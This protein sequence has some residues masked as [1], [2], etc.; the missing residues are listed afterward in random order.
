MFARYTA[1]FFTKYTYYVRKVGISLSLFD[2]L[3]LLA[4]L[5]FFF[6]TSA[7]VWILVKRPGAKQYAVS[8]SLFGLGQCALQFYGRNGQITNLAQG[9]TDSFP[10]SWLEFS[11]F[12]LAIIVS[13]AGYYSDYR[14]K[15]PKQSGQT[16]K[17]KIFKKKTK[18][19]PPPAS[20][21]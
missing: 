6:A 11:L 18:P 14:A 7:C 9:T 16:T 20:T 19:D 8:I 10:A 3:S 5:L 17:F 21:S 4:L 2:I 12:C 1:R 15:H 13:L